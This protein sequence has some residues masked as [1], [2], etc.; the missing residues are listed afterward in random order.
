[1]L[2]QIFDSSIA[3][4]VTVSICLDGAFQQL[5]HIQFIKQEKQF[6]FFLVEQQMKLSFFSDS[7]LKPKTK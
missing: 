7:P 2:Q 1:M 5:Q 3:K 4:I 6:F